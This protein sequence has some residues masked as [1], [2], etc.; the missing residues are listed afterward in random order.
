MS[1]YTKIIGDIGT[2][3]VISEFLKHGINVLLPYDDNSPYDIVIHIDNK[4]Y[5]IQVKT[6]E[7][8]KYNGSEMQFEATKSNPYSK[9]DPKY[10]EEEVDYFAL[11]C[12]ENDW[13]GLIGFDEYT[14]QLIIR[15][16]P[17]KNNQKEKIKF[18][19]DYL[20]HDQILK[21]FN[22]DYI[23]NNI[24]HTEGDSKTYSN[25]R[26]MKK[27]PVCNENM[28]RIRSNMCR[29]C[30]RKSVQKKDMKTN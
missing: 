17:T 23:K 28:I 22:R 30:Y 8:V 4:F 24:V 3:V 26:K 20:I 27:C 5:K 12:I 15:L 1:S 13:C 18:A 11:Y 14:P 6:T 19:N 16:K 10:T 9:I 21:F 7:K 2:S 29:E 25:K